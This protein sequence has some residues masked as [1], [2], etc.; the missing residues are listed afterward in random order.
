MIMALEIAKHV[1]TVTD[2][3]RMAETGILSEN[4]RVELIEGEII[5]M[6]PIGNRHAACVDRFNELIVGL[7]LDV[8]VRVQ[9]SIQLDD[10]WQPQPDLALLR[11]RDDFYSGSRP[12]AADVLLV[13]EVADTALEYD[14]FVKLPAYARAGIPEVWLANLPADRIEMYAEP[15]NGA[16]TVIKHATRGE[17]IESSSIDELRLSVDDILG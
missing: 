6:S 12:R 3:E 10:Y 15:V 13:I 9:S 11:R 4:D 2:F 5:E 16:H 7:R 1:F 17:V 8:I 14:R